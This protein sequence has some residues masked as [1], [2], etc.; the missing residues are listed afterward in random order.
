[1]T[2][3]V[4]YKLPYFTYISI[5]I[6]ILFPYVWRRIYFPYLLSNISNP[7]HNRYFDLCNGYTKGKMDLMVKN[8]QL[9]KLV[10]L[11]KENSGIVWFHVINSF[12]KRPIGIT[13]NILFIFLKIKTSKNNILT[14]LASPSKN[15]WNMQHA[16]SCNLCEI[17]LDFSW[18]ITFLYVRP[19]FISY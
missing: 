2:N 13:L 19:C 1:M 8:K 7:L 12:R 4:L 5:S 16:I 11:F 6:Y 10:H 17:L 18:R 9:W 15:I 3:F 14:N